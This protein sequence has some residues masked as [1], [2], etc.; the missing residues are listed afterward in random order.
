MMVLL[1]MLTRALPVMV[2]VPM[3]TQ[4]LPWTGGSR[5]W[6]CLHLAASVH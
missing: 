3:A 5:A 2:M 4:R 6:L 1:P